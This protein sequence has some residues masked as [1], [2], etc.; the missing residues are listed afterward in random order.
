MGISKREV[1]SFYPLERVAFVIK[2]DEVGRMDLIGIF[3]G[4]VA[5]GVSLPFDEV[6]ELSG[7]SITSVAFDQLHFVFRFSINQIRW[8]SGEIGAV[9]GSFAIGR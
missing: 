2:F 5:F 4:I 7:P 3:P 1:S 8:R 9:R 6:L